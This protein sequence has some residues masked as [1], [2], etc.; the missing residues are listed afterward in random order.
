MPL[1]RANF[2][3][4]L[5]RDAHPKTWNGIAIKRSVEAPEYRHRNKWGNS[6]RMTSSYV[7]S[8]TSIAYPG[9]GCVISMDN[10]NGKVYCVT[11]TNLPQCTCLNILRWHQRPLEIRVNR[12]TASTCYVYYI[13]QYFC[14]INY[15]VD[16]F[17]HAPS[18][19]YNNV[20]RVLELAKVAKP[21]VNSFQR[22][23]GV[24]SNLCNLWK[25]YYR[26]VFLGPTLFILVK[27][28]S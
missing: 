21:R 24:L 2:S 19:N 10:G 26:Q 7:T 4:P 5:N 27:N 8:L 20:M 12:C 14:K 3:T 17:M 23:K 22:M 9:Y 13:F 11:V 28:P 1:P 16:I 25:Y 6:R 18:F 15:K